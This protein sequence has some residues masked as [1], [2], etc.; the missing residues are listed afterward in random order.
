MNRN[1]FF[2]SKILLIGEYSLLLG[3]A[4]LAIPWPACSA[5]WAYSGQHPSSDLMKLLK[6]IETNP[7]IN[8][9]IDSAFFEKEIA[10]GLILESNIPY[11]Y[12]LGSSGVL[13]AAVADRFGLQQSN[14]PEE[15]YQLLKDMESF[16]HG[17]SSGLDPLVSYFNKAIYMKQG[18]F[19]IRN[20]TVSDFLLKNQIKL[21]DSKKERNTKSLVKIFNENINDTI[22]AKKMQDLSFHNGQFIDRLFSGESSGLAEPWKEISRLSLDVFDKMIPQG[23]K[24]FWF[25]GLRDNSYYLKLCGAGGG[26]LFLVMVIDEQLFN[27]SV[28]YFDV[29]LF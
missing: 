13:C 15:I 18:N 22:Y 23:L 17:S 19:E 6:F 2:P 16:F 21:I 11:G 29:Q 8:T 10:K 14:T 25:Q 9:K 28:E 12:G 20:L 5:K 26:G 3:Q 27:S 7:S 24:L 4:G 1:E